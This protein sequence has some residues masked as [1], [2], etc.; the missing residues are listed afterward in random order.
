MLKAKGP[1][2]LAANHPNSFLDGVILTTLFDQR[3]YSLARGDVFRRSR[4]DKLLRWLGLLP[5]FRSTEGTEFLG[6]NYTTFE[7]CLEGFEENKVVL[8]FSEGRCENE[9]YLRPLRKGTARLANSAWERNIPLQVLP[10][11]INYSSF[12]KFGKDIHL[13]F[14]NP[15]GKLGKEENYGRDLLAFNQELNG[16]LEGL[17]YEIDPGDTQKQKAIFSHDPTPLKRGL[18]FLPALAGWLLH[19]PFYVIVRGLTDLKFRDSGH[20]D[21]VLICGLMVLYPVYLLLIAVILFQIDP[22]PALAAFFVLPFT[23]WSYAQNG[24]TI[25]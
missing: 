17:V 8:I 5:V 3:I 20:Y 16:Q 14:G 10:V 23:G 11:G 22:L 19:L 24:F 18:L 15:F 21:S 6:H 9:W 4:H 7:A 1:L 2:L 13:L 12:K 25:I